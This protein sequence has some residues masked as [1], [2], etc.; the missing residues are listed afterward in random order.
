[1]ADAGQHRRALVDLP[2]DPLAH[3]VEGDGRLAHLA[4]AARREVGDG[5]ALAEIVDGRGQ[6]RIGRIWLR[7]KTMAMASS[8]T[9][10]ATIHQ[11]KMSEF[12][13]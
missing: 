8:T 10:V 6:R 11:M 13:M 7:R 3:L 4:G 5:A 2:L 1:M 12:E 9:E